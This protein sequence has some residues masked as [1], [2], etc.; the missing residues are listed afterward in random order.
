MVDMVHV[1][2]IHYDMIMQ[3]QE[4][5]VGIVVR[6]ASLVFAVS[7]RGSKRGRLLITHSVSGL[8]AHLNAAGVVNAP[9]GSQV[10]S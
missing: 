8:S 4:A 5:G 10:K 9:W 1:G 3:R 6:V 7:R 2:I